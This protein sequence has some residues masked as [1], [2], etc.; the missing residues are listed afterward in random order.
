MGNKRITKELIS[1]SMKTLM[2][3]YPF[4]KI[5]VRM[6]ADNAGII[7]PTFY[8]YFCDKYEVL[9]WIFEENV[10]S[11]MRSMFEEKMYREGIKTL[12]VCI[13][14]DGTFYKKAFEVEGQN[15]FIEI[16]NK[17]LQKLFYEE[18]G[19]VNYDDCGITNPLLNAEAVSTFYALAVS[20]ILQFWMLTG[21]EN[22]KIDDMVDAFVFLLNN[23]IKEKF[24]V[25][26]N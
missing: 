12:F 9:E 3:D 15:G 2:K 5:T 18:L 25:T 14:N 19:A 4:D 17:H 6:I 26:E 24:R 21:V 22:Y 20:H 10:V 16:V 11:K 23:Q 13:R 8:N 7:R 1:E